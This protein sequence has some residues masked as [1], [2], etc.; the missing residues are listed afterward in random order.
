M[1]KSLFSIFQHIFASTY[2]NFALG[3]ELI[4]Q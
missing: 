3:V 4:E 1:W 2:K